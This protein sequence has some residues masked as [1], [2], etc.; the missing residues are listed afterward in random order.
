MKFALVVVET[1]DSR[2]HV[3]EHRSDH[4]ARIEAWMAEQGGAGKLVGGEAFETGAIG[5]VTVRRAGGGEV[6]VTEGPFAGA[7]ETPGGFLLVDVADR[8][9]AVELAKSWPTEETI[10][11]RPIWVAS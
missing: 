3:R 5:P 1:E 10:E 9:E 4:R 11:V 7:A 2:R 8:D 6:T